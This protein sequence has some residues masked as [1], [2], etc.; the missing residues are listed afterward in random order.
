M[1]YPFLLF[2]IVAFIIAT[3]TLSQDVDEL[4]ELFNNTRH[5]NTTNNETIELPPE[6][7]EIFQYKA[8]LVEPNQYLIYWK[9]NETDITFELQANTTGWIG[10]GLSPDGGMYMSDVIIAWMYSDGTGHFSGYLPIHFHNF[11]SFL[12]NNLER[13]FDFD[14]LL[15]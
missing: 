15:K 11:I 9:Y 2:F 3:N 6:P 13:L 12:F 7:S 14:M 4:N 1:R 10:F 8:T 5:E